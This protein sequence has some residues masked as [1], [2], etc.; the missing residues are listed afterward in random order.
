MFE[1]KTTPEEIK[2]A[3]EEKFL[4]LNEVLLEDICKLERDSA[5]ID[6]DDRFVD[7]TRQ[8]LYPTEADNVKGA[9]Q[10]YGLGES[11]GLDIVVPGAEVGQRIRVRIKDRIKDAAF[12]LPIDDETIAL[13]RKVFY[14]TREMASLYA[15]EIAKMLCEDNGRI[16]KS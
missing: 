13:R 8:F 2:K 10:P 14:Y 12:G 16:L 15:G 9:P 11:D 7:I 3:R 5:N 4:F 1:G 6:E